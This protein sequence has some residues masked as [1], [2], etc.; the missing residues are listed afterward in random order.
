MR[1]ETMAYWRAAAEDPR[2]RVADRR[3]RL[4]GDDGRLDEAEIERLAKARD[5]RTMDLRE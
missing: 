5:D 2:G 3:A 4:L 1:R